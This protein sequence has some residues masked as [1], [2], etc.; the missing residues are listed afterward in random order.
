M[1]AHHDRFGHALGPSRGF[2]DRLRAASGSQFR[3]RAKTVAESLGGLDRASGGAHQED[4]IVVDT[5]LQPLRRSLRLLRPAW[6]QAPGKIACGLFFSFSM[7]PKNEV[8]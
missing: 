1:P 6:G 4:C 3:D 5:I 8:H 7:T 2:E